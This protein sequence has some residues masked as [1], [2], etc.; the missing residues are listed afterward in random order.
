MMAM[1]IDDRQRPDGADEIPISSAASV[2]P[3]Y[4]QFASEVA[5]ASRC[6][7]GRVDFLRTGV[8]LHRAREVAAM[9]DLAQSLGRSLPARDDTR[10]AVD[11]PVADDLSRPEP[12][13]PTG[14]TA[15]YFLGRDPSRWRTGI[16]IFGGLAYRQVRP[17]VDLV[18]TDRGGCL[19]GV[20]QSSADAGAAVVRAQEPV[21]S[22]WALD[23][24]TYFGGSNVDGGGDV[25]SD[26][27]V[28]GAGA[29][30]IAG[31]TYSDD[32]PTAGPVQ[33]LK[34]GRA[35]M[36][37]TK[38]D[39]TGSR[40][41]YSTFI[42][43]EAVEQAHG[44]VVDR[45]G[46]VTVVG[47]TQSPDFPVVKAFQDHL[48]VGQCRVGS[49]LFQCA[50]SVVLRLDASGSSLLFSSYYG[51][52]SYDQLFDASLAPDGTVWA[53][54]DT[55]SRDLALIQPFQPTYGGGDSD[56]MV[57][58]I[59]PDG[60][61]LAQAS[62]L[63]GSAIDQGRAIDSNA[64]TTVVTGYANSSDFPRVGSDQR[65]TA[66]GF[67][68]TLSAIDHEDLRLSYSALLGGSAFDAGFGVALDGAGGMA[69]VGRSSSRNF[70]VARPLQPA[71]KGKVDG[72]LVVLDPQH[73]PV[74]STLIGG[75]ETGE[76]T[77]A[78]TDVAFAD[79]KSLVVVGHTSAADFPV[80]APVQPKMGGVIDASIT[81]IDFSQPAILLGT[82]LGG[83]GV[84]EPYGLVID[85][86]G[87]IVVTGKTDS[88]DLPLVNPFSRQLGGRQDVFVAALTGAFPLPT[89]TATAEPTSTATATSTH[90]PSSTP[91]ASATGT[92]RPVMTTT[93][94]TTPI[95]FMHVY[96]PRCEP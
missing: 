15:N 57:L 30:Y 59:A 87:R 47:A 38:L 88:A 93:P 14:A 79:N 70:P 19:A 69:V 11:L 51:G 23:L 44:L 72:F 41:V 31:T 27:A 96:L 4:G 77:E 84:D 74:H 76:E 90:T 2:V 68:A 46:Q 65:G 95:A 39:R 25:G 52:S 5:F 60:A 54:G 32:L 94:T 71:L 48:T 1:A 8:R 85:A 12:V 18:F 53:V 3:N 16:P 20:Y 24:S 91:S 66:G 67:D 22:E 86:G 81:Y 7:A 89:S 58:A 34:S 42:G 49:D 21:A 13:D 78:L 62:Y 64:D 82:L 56:A 9:P 17:G 63:G 50:D 73:A 26:L 45:L 28:D 83:S 37:V 61:E 29:I 80:R 33:A 10:E 40:L 36:F 75:Y 6:G 43:G 35:D 92:P 55:W